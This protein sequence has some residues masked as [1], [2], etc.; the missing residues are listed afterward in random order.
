VY[1]SP[2]DPSLTVKKTLLWTIPTLIPLAL[3]AAAMVILIQWIRSEQCRT[4][5]E[6]RTES[7]LDAQTELAPLDWRWLGVASPRFIATGRSSTPLRRMEASGLRA[8]LSPSSMLQGV[9]G[10]KEISLDELQLHIG[11]PE[12]TST[13]VTPAAPTSPAGPP[14]T[15]SLPKWVPSLVVIDV[16]HGKKTDLFIETGPTSI[17]LLGTDLKARP[18]P[19]GNET[20][21][22]LT[23]GTLGCSRYPDLKLSLKT[24]R[25]RLTPKGLDLTGAD[26]TCPQGGLIRLSGMFPS[27]GTPSSL[28]VTCEKLPVSVLLPHFG[29][30]VTGLIAGRS[31]MRWGAEGKRDGEGMIRGEEITLTGIPGLM[32]FAD[33][34]G[35]EQFRRL[36]VQTFSS[37]F[38]VHD[39]VTEWRDLVFESQGFLKI[40]GDAKTNLDGS[41]SG[42]IQLGITTR[43]VNM[44]PFARELLGLEERDGYIWS[45]EPITIGGTLSHPTENFSPR[46]MTI[47]AAGAEG[48][49]RSGVRAGLGIIGVKTGDTNLPAPASLPPAATNSATDAVKTLEQGAGAALDALGGFL[50]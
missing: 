6:R 8:S 12:T 35:L 13:T 4:L 10:V 14:V 7:V 26:F 30:K 38:S 44:I 40:T 36:P 49:V 2:E 16:I 9:W 32:K 47:V 31:T 28:S 15:S 24:A 23:G 42:T 22:K 29:D 50:K 41:L 17:T 34:T 18:S 27:D 3:L 19:S 48:V 25:C 5:L 33:L 37:G 20:L 39:S 11:S 21:F 43:I 46:L 45:R 1:K